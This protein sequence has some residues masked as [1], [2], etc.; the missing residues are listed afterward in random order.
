RAFN[1]ARTL[2]EEAI[3]GGNSDEAIKQ[4][5]AQMINHALLAESKAV[6]DELGAIIRRMQRYAKTKALASIDQD[7]VDRI[8]ELLEGYNFRNVSD[9][10]RREM[11]R[12]EAWAE[13]Q[14]QLGHDLVVPERFGDVRT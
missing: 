2:F 13:C 14:R 6:Q 4:K 8:H 10:A 5:Q 7:Y 9:A 1:K 12:F 11:A 3:L